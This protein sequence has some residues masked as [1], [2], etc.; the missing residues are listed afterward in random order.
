MKNLLIPFLIAIFF[1]ACNSAQAQSTFDFF[2]EQNY[3]QI[4]K[5]LDDEVDIQINRKKQLASKQKAI[6]IL[7]E[8][9]GRFNPDRWELIH[10]GEADESGNSYFIA[11]V[12][13][14]E[15]KGLR[16]FVH[17]EGKE[18]SGK[19]TSIRFRNLL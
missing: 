19:I 17:L 3:N 13:N 6:A 10:R 2:Q 16:I 5:L 7:K 9:L 4:Y 15:D 18:P 14:S 11:K 1:I 12:F 8:K